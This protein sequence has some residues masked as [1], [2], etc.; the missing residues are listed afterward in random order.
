MG[1]A[2]QPAT[3]ESCGGV[4]PPRPEAEREGWWRDG[5]SRLPLWHCPG[6]A[7]AARKARGLEA[8]R[9]PRLS[10]RAAAVVGMALAFKGK[11]GIR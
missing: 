11:A 7:P 8:G 5:R 10:P 4:G 9:R 3:C 1:Q 6:C 2:S